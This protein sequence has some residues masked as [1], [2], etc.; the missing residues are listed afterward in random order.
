MYTSVVLPH[1]CMERIYREDYATTANPESPLF[2]LYDTELERVYLDDI[3]HLQMFERPPVNTE[4]GT[5]K[6]HIACQSYIRNMR[7]MRT[8]L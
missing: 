8:T 5:Y 4:I 3:K 2:I 1:A 7:A 6:C